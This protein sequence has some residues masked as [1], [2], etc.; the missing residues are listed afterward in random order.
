MAQSFASTLEPFRKG[1]SFTHWVERL[2]FVFM[3][4]KIPE[5]ERKAH[6]VTLVGPYVY[7]ELKLLF[8]T[9]SLTD[10]P[11][12]TMIERLKM[13]LDKTASGV[14]QRISFNQR[15]QNVDESAEDFLLA[16]KLQAELCAYGAF[17]D[18]AIRDR[19]LAGLKDVML[20]QRI[21]SEADQ[22]LESAEKIIQTW[23]A[24]KNNV[25]TLSSEP[26]SIHNVVSMASNGNTMGKAM[27]KLAAAYNA[28][29]NPIPQKQN[30]RLP[31]KDRLGFRPYGNPRY[32]KHFGYNR[33]QQKNTWKPNSNFKPADFRESFETRICDF[34]GLKGHLKKRCFRLKNMKKEAVKLVEQMKPGT[35]GTSTQNISDLMNR[36]RT[37][38]SDNDDSDE[39]GN[40]KRQGHRTSKST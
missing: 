38:E 29:N 21:L 26:F 37:E 39:G 33:Y 31:V 32:Q 8:P 2:D 3:A 9:G 4:N 25:K 17:K 1:T 13:R 11:L 28:A 16:L 36:M 24:A 40:W 5:A 22:T 27:G 20:K 23:E 15:I 14:C 19:L 12:N 10:V 30:S 6:F 18:T 35:S 7:S 34:C